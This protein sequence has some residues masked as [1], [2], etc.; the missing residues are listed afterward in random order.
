MAHLDDIVI[1]VNVAR[2][3][4]ISRAARSL[5]M[6]VSTVSRRL[7][8]L[9]SRMR[10]T[11]LR[12]TTR[13]VTLTAEGRDYFSRCQEPLLLLQQAEQTLVRSQTRTEGLLNITLPVSLGQDPFLEFVSH[14]L[15]NHPGIRI[16]LNF[17]NV[18]LDLLAE[19]LD[20]A[21]R[22]GELE[23][24]S[25]VAV[26]LG[27]TVRHVVAAPG[28]LRD[29]RPPVEPSDLG[30]HACVLLRARNGEADWRLMNGRRKVRV[31]V[32]GPLTASD[33]T[34][35]SS[36]V[37]RGHG[38]GLLEPHNYTGKPGGAELIRVLPG[39]TSPP[40]PVF[41]VYASRKYIPSRLRAFLD[42][43]MAWKSPPWTPI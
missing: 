25:V 20:L 28:Y 3:E 33:I 30:Q 17:T 31:H 32:T 34:S 6:P 21:I 11:L 43:L 36:F 23:D 14:F 38:I 41:A 40:I 24:S 27:T 19:N 18:Y 16:A 12:R 4:S 1:F 13:K 7:A 15:K 5:G 37:R 9:E 10:V 35:V 22:F 2:F 42:A 8:A 26:R 29:R 39:W